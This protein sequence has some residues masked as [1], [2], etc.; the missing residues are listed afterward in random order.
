MKILNKSLLALALCGLIM[1]TY[2][3]EAK[4]SYNDPF[5]DDFAR[6]QKDMDDMFMN[7]HQK[8]F[9]DTNTRAD[10]QMTKSDFKENNSSYI[11]TLTL[12]GYEE[13][14]LY[15]K[16]K[17]QTLIIEATKQTSSEKK[18]AHYHQQE[19]FEGS[20]YQSFALPNNAEISKMKKE[21]KN[22]ILTITIPKK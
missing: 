9:S 18:D 7:F 8:Y 2:A 6:L 13:S 5:Y 4:K 12:V 21:F 20:M 10:T 15:V 19:H 16:E 14:N 11:I 1:N 17:D 3:D 22:G